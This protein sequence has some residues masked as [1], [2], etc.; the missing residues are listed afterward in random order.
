[1]DAAAELTAG[2]A[3]SLTA[4]AEGAP[5]LEALP[6]EEG[7]AVP[8]TTS[9]IL[10]SNISPVVVLFCIPK[11]MLKIISHIKPQVK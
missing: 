3:E 5:A 1:M 11:I 9:D 4:P 8:F 6:V 7:F 2:A 10:F